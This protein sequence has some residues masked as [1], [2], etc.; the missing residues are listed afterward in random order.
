M[1]SNDYYMNYYYDNMHN[2][3]VDLECWNNTYNYTWVEIQYED[4]TFW[5]VSVQAS[6]TLY[7]LMDSSFCFLLLFCCCFIWASTQ[8][9]LSSGFP[10]K[11]GS[12]Q[13]NELQRLARKLKFHR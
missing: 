9:N 5:Q 6:L 4:I 12:T 1:S 7:T 10:T 2:C 13:S 3:S 11:R 8:Q